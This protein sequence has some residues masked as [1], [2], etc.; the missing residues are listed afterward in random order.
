ME[1]LSIF[2][3]NHLVGTLSRHTKGRV[4]FQYGQHWLKTVG[5][6]ISLSLPCREEKFPPALSTAFFENLLPESDAR[7]ILAFN[8]RF[9]KKDTFSFLNLYGRDCAGA[10]SIMPQGEKPDLTPW[11]YEDVTAKLTK[12]LDRLETSS[13]QRKLYLEMQPAR[14]SIAG[15]QDKLPVYFSENKFYLPT[16]SGSAT[17]HIIKPMSPMF[18]GI[19]RNEAFCMDI[20]RIIGIRVPN[21]KLIQMGPHEL[22]LVERFDRKILP[23]RVARIHQEDFCQA[24]G[25]PVDRKYQIKGGPGFRQCRSLIDEYLNP[26]AEIRAE[27]MDK[28]PLR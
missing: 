21:S 4:Q 14:L 15:V 28:V 26:S 12:A 27:I 2:L 10:L 8:N 23:D 3:G 9:N 19:Q 5:L 7:S 20:A 22:Y 13:D 1:N 11:C 25:L 6:P 24:M 18:P 17:T 16:N